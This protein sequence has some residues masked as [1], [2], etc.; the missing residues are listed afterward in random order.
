MASTGHQTSPISRVVAAAAV[1]G[2]LVAIFHGLSLQGISQ[3]AATALAVALMHLI[4]AMP[5]LQGQ[6]EKLEPDKQNTGSTVLR[7]TG[8]LQARTSR[9]YQSALGSELSWLAPW[10]V[11][12]S[13]SIELLKGLLAGVATV[14]LQRAIAALAPASWSEWTVT[15]VSVAGAVAI[16]HAATVLIG[17]GMRSASGLS[18]TV[19]TAVQEFPLLKRVLV[20]QPLPVEAVKGVL[21]GCLVVLLRGPFLAIAGLFANLWLAAGAALFVVA[22]VIL[23]DESRAILRWLAEPR[24]KK[25]TK[26]ADA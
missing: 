10:L 6:S 9:V 16:L 21:K 13:A 23:P 25:E 4:S 17:Q 2:G 3:M 26:N 5:R 14:V 7:L 19:R 20:R 24:S 18:P 8:G 11:R 15:A 22:I 12:G 1:A